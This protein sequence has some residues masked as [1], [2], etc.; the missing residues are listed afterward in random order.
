MLQAE[1]CDQEHRTLS[2][3]ILQLPI[4]LHSMTLVD[5][6]GIKKMNSTSFVGVVIFIPKNYTYRQVSNISRTLV[7]N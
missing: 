2:Y 7:G 5:I 6:L 4:T 1:T 3:P